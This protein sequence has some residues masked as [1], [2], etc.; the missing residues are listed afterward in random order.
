MTAHLAAWA[1]Q[2][3]TAAHLGVLAAEAGMSTR[4]GREL[5]REAQVAAG[6]AERSWTAAVAAAGLLRGR[7]PDPGAEADV[8]W[9]DDGE[10]GDPA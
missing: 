4:D 6:R 9:L 3:V 1:W 7:A 10:G 2:H 8:P 5:T